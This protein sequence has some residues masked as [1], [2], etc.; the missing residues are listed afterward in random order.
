MSDRGI[1]ESKSVSLE[2]GTSY[3]DTSCP[4][5]EDLLPRHMVCSYAAEHL[6]ASQADLKDAADKQVTRPIVDVV[7]DESGE[8]FPKDYL[9]RQFVNE[10][11]ECW[12]DTDETERFRATLRFASLIDTLR[13]RLD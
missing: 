2:R 11:D 12:L 10:V 7:E 9:A 1:P 5:I 4:E 8:R 3:L 13:E 6:D